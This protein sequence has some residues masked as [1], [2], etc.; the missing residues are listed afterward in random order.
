MRQAG[1]PP[2]AGPDREVLRRQVR[3]AAAAANDLPGFLAQLRADGVLVRERYSQQHPEQVTG[4]ASCCQGAPSMSG[5][6]AAS[7]PPI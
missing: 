5:S 6:A 1:R 2:A 7:S 3:V 4:Y